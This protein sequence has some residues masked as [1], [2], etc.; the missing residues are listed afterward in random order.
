MHD[1]LFAHEGKL[2]EDDIED[3]AEAIGLDMEQW[4]ADRQDPAI[5]QII[6]E[7]MELAKQLGVSGAPAS[8]VNGMFVSGAQPAETFDAVI[9]K[10]R[11]GGG[12]LAEAEPAA[13]QGGG[14]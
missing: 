13:A 12:G 8:F 3:A 9:A 11:A 7:D 6:A 10:E 14:G 5:E 1:A 2:D 4:N